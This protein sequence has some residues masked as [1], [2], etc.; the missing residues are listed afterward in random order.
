MTKIW[1]WADL[2]LPLN[3]ELRDHVKFWAYHMKITKLRYWY[4]C[5]RFLT[6]IQSVVL[7]QYKKDNYSSSKALA[8]V[9]Q[10]L[11]KVELKDQ[12]TWDTTINNNQH[13]I[14]TTQLA[15]EALTT[16]NRQC[17]LRTINI[18]Q[19]QLGRSPRGRNTVC[20]ETWSRKW[21][22][23]VIYHHHLIIIYYHHHNNN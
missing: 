13:N 15:P 3:F 4:H 5:N 16:R 1:L 8:K 21:Y 20:I 18:R 6:L 17:A 22:W 12:Y 7:L 23:Y 9:C 11:R 2:N 19:L 10:S 14:I